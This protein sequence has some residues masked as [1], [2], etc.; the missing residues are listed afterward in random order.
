MKRYSTSLTITEM[1]VRTPMRYHL[2]PVT[3]AILKTN[4]AG[5]GVEKKEPCYTV[6]GM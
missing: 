6:V 3:M 5:E 2:T 1:C 4:N